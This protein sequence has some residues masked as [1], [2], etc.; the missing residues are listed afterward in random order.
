[1]G[2]F[3][4]KA[5]KFN[6]IG[7]AA[8]DNSDPEQIGL[9]AVRY[10]NFGQPVL[11]SKM[12][13]G[14]VI[15]RW[16]PETICQPNHIV[17]ERFLDS[18][19]K[20][21]SVYD[22]HLPEFD[23]SGKHMLS[24]PLIKAALI[25]IICDKE[26]PVPPSH[27]EQWE[28]ERVVPFSILNNVC[29]WGEAAGEGT[30]PAYNPP[31]K[32]LTIAP[33][34]VSGLTVEI[35]GDSVT[36]YSKYFHVTF[37]LRR[38][39]ITELGWD[40]F[41][42]GNAAAN[43]LPHATSWDFGRNVP[44][45]S[46]C[47]PM[48]ID[49]NDNINARFFTGTVEVNGT[50]V[51]YKNIRC[52]ENYHLDI[53]FTVN[54][55]GFDIEVVKCVEQDYSAIECDDWRFVWDCKTSIIGT[56]GNKIRLDTRTG[57]LDFPIVWNAPA[58][59]SVGLVSDSN[60]ISVQS[61][62]YRNLGC[63]WCGFVL[64]GTKDKYG[65]LHFKKGRYQAKVNAK[66]DPA[67]LRGCS[68]EQTP[69]GLK[70]GIGAGLGFRSELAGYSNNSI[71]CSCH[72]SHYA[73]A[74]LSAY[75]GKFNCGVDP[76]EMLR[77][78]MELSLRGGPG[79][80]DNRHMYIDSDPSVLVAVGMLQNAAPDDRWIASMWPLIKK[81]A[82]RIT[83]LIDESDL[84]CC[85]ALTGNSGSKRWS[86]NGWDVLSFGNYDA[87]SNALA[88][89]G[90]SY[91]TGI[92]GNL[93]D[94]EAEKKYGSAALGIKENFERVLKNPETGL[95][96]GWVSADGQHHDYYFTFINNMAV[97]F[98]LVG[99]ETALHIMKEFERE[100]D[101]LGLH[102]FGYGLPTNLLS[103]KNIDAPHGNDYLRADG[104]D[105][106]GIYVNGSMF[107]GWMQYYLRALKLC[108]FTEKAE[109][110]IRQ[111]DDSLAR[112]KILGGYGTGTEFFSW[113]GRPCGYEGVLVGQFSTLGTAAVLLGLVDDIM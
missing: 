70:R 87:Y 44:I 72:L 92:A 112:R 46:Y 30:E 97:T 65:Y 83:D 39:L 26:H 36:Y 75:M 23:D 84:L 86:S 90:L 66:I 58:Y 100:M 47:G 19:S 64:G 81:A 93:G 110:V 25:R 53:T 10:F 60:D 40:D 11:L 24:L 82:D 51:R 76:V 1:M 95:I 12:E 42:E 6:E 31:L 54:E 89:Q 96:S 59:G 52:N 98:G 69:P 108:G 20:W 73:A 80:G 77:Y 48:L 13:I 45:N 29:F 109:T 49:A 94:S 17:I 33:A 41:G 88:F 8:W 62:S 18:G 91:I 9:A 35:L 14:T 106:F 103:V 79:Y 2:V 7:H 111:I 102:Y 28:K 22:M 32:K 105:S 5:L 101:E 67:V 55:K 78:T 3:L 68:Y 15:T 21:E 4:M 74:N 27:G 113:E 34:A 107:L 37:S 63:T 50:E 57:S 16:A 99:K 61:D 43:F 56:L 104:M 71:S 38:P 85:K